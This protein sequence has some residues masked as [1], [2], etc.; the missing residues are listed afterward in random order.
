[1]S[2]LEVFI[3]FSFL[4]VGFLFLALVWPWFLLVHTVSRTG[5]IKRWSRKERFVGGVLALGTIATL[6]VPILGIALYLFASVGTFVLSQ[7]FD[8]R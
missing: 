4:L 7:R 5:G 3:P 8:A 6:V 1:M 2:K